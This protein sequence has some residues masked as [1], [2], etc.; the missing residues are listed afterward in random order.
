MLCQEEEEEQLLR[1]AASYL[2]HIACTCIPY[3]SLDVSC[4][5]SSTRYY[6]VSFLHGYPFPLV[7][8]FWRWAL[9]WR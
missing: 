6:L 9:V 1:H 2:C 5:A 3:A 8:A 7:M 4:A